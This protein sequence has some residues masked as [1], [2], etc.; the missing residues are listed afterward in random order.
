[1][2]PF[3]IEFL[4][5]ALIEQNEAPTTSAERADKGSEQQQNDLSSSIWAELKNVVKNVAK[6]A[7]ESRALSPSEPLDFS[8]D[9]LYKNFASLAAQAKVADVRMQQPPG[10]KPTEVTP[11]PLLSKGSQVEAQS[12]APEAPPAKPETTVTGDRAPKPSEAEGTGA[13]AF[14]GEEIKRDV[15]PVTYTVE[16]NDN[17]T[18]IA[19]A[20]LG[21]DASNQEVQLH[22]REIARLNKI[23]NPNIIHPGQELQLPGHTADGGTVLNEAGKRTTTWADGTYR[24]DNADR[25]G[26]VRTP[27]GTEMHWGPKQ[28][29][30]FEVR[31]TTDGGTAITDH[32]GA[33]TT[34]WADGVRRQENPDG[35]GNVRR[36]AEGGGYTE[37]HWGPNPT[38][39]YDL[40]KTNDGKYRIADGEGDRTGHEPANE[41]ERLQAERARLNDR[42]EE[43]F[44]NDP[45]ALDRA[46]QDMAAFERRAARQN[47]PLSQEEIAKTYDQVSKLL[48]STGE[49]PVSQADRAKLAEQVLHQA[50]HPNEV[51]QGSHG[52]CNVASVENRIYNRDPSAAA[53]VVTEAAT[54]GQ[55]TMADGRVVQVPAASLQPDTQGIH[56]P[57]PDGERSHA[58]QI[59]QVVAVNDRYD[60]QNRST[61]PPGQI[62]YE[63]DTPT[64]PNDTGERLWD[65]STT[66]RQPATDA[67]GNQL[68]P[69]GVPTGELQNISNDITGKT[70][71]GFAIVNGRYGDANTVKV[72]SAEELGQTLEQMKREGKLPAIIWVDAQNEP[73]F[74][75][76]GAGTNGGSGGAHV[77]TITDYDPATG[78]AQVDN[79]W[80]QADD[81]EVSIHDLYRATLP[82][83]DSAT[84]SSYQSDVA[85]DRAFGTED[86]VKELELLRLQRNA[87]QTTDAQYDT[88]VI[89][90]MRAQQQRWAERG[91]TYPGEQA[92]TTAKYQQLLRFMPAARAAAVRAAVSAP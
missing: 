52:T 6:S 54:T 42:L 66:P 27:D 83:T 38:D 48:E 56:H 69:P 63:Q 10:D 62:R 85:W 26:Y 91:E 7:D 76:S 90:A 11:D 40:V 46:Q 67:A 24:I 64:G 21:P 59:F 22:V 53:R 31:P 12:P 20:H 16:K 5:M 92:A 55:V 61:T 17:L 58:S 74:T 35:T 37:H 9:N 1:M 60:R 77:V 25:T 2:I 88:Q 3:E 50:A 79:Q 75:D 13:A 8:T 14:H 57:S 47:P 36:P 51:R 80:D 43:R 33:I 82:S 18:E 28:T 87:N 4:T 68:S 29:D 45:E 19:R 71:T 86:G 78:R 89:A 73:F 49:Q 15:E 81:H 72:R 84:I 32:R 34:T 44:A 23:S 39:N 41:T 65:Y 70:E 30:N